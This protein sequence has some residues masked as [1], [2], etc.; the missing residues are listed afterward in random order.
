MECR[1]IVY[2][3]TE[4]GGRRVRIDG[5]ILG[6]AYSPVDLLEFL[7]RAGLDLDTVD[8]TDTD[9]F[10]WRGEGPAVWM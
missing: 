8:L 4:T 3:P 7:R 10:E 6:V 2:P 1:V 9:F 5:T